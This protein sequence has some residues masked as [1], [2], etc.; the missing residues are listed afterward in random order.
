MRPAELEQAQA[1]NQQRE[2]KQEAQLKREPTGAPP[3]PRLPVS[4]RGIPILRSGEF[5]CAAFL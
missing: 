3:F 5:R 1:A 2:Q 4:Q